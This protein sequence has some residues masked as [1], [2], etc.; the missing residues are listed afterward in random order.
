M[1]PF[2]GLLIIVLVAKAVID[3]GRREYRA[4]REHHA[5]QIARDHPDWHPRKVSRSAGRRAMA[6]WWNE[7]AAWPPFPSARAAF[8]EER[9]TARVAAEEARAAGVVRWQDLR[10]RLERA[11]AA[12]REHQ[13]TAMTDDVPLPAS[14]DGA[15]PAA[16]LPSETVGGPGRPLLVRPRDEPLRPGMHEPYRVPADPEP[17]DLAQPD[18]R[19]DSS[20]LEPYEERCEGCGGT[21][22]NGDGTDAC[23][24]CRGWGSKPPDPDAPPWWHGTICRACGN[25][26]TADDPVVS[27]SQIHRSHVVEAQARYQEA[28][29]RHRQAKADDAPAGMCDLCPDQAP[30]LPGDC[31]RYPDAPP[32]DDPFPEPADD[33]WPTGVPHRR[34]GYDATDPSHDAERERDLCPPSPATTEGDRVATRDT[35]TSDGYW[36]PY[37]GPA[38]PTHQEMRGPGP[39][40]PTANGGNMTTGTDTP[41]DTSLENADTPH[42]AMQGAFRQIGAR[43]A[44]F[45]QAASDELAAAAAVH[46]MDRDPQTMS[47]IA[48]L[49][50]HA[51]ALQQQANLAATGLAQ[52]HAEGA[53]YHSTGTDAHASAYRPS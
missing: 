39:G 42:E 44:E 6:H 5:A 22:G 45:A 18:G 40:V 52:R 28:L 41:I 16:P 23:P 25:P 53:E 26:G 36:D 47:D 8:A 49:A 3:K 32:A 2:I 38:G 29:A 27:A 4:T 9:M 35:N 31:V 37:R 48:A 20:W 46:G 11:M 10:E 19:R 14:G 17:D 34:N 43:A 30:H 51:Q 33:N 50:D 21:G 7:F 13:G 12:Q 24:V 1:D 15:P